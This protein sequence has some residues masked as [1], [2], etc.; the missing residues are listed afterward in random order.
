MHRFATVTATGLFPSTAAGHVWQNVIPTQAQNEPLLMHGLLALSGMD[1]AQFDGEMRGTYRTRALHH[2]QIGLTIFQEMLAQDS[3]AQIHTIFPFSLMLIILAYASVHS[4][5]VEW[6]VDAILDLFALYRGP[7]MLAMSNW[8][9]IAGSEMLALLR[10]GDAAKEA[11]GPSEPVQAALQQLQSY[12]S[13]EVSRTAVKL[14]ADAIEISASSFDMRVIGRWPSMLSEEF[15]VR[16]REHQ[17]EA[18]VILS[19]YSIALAAF[20]DRWWVGSWDKKLVSA[21]A[22]ELPEE[23][24]KEY[25]W[26]ADALELVLDRHA[27]ASQR[28]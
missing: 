23:E 15:F 1:L 21:V 2:Q 6:S 11:D 13:D 14:L 18:L 10:P 17:P 12:P 8:K 9:A 4:E 27:S 20:R 28:L 3:A 5:N 22:R 26:H 16:L 24:Q 7:R 25:G 19:Y